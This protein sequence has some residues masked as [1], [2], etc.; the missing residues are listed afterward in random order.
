M[1]EKKLTKAELDKVGLV[2]IEID[3]Q[4][5]QKLTA[6]FHY[7]ATQK[8]PLPASGVNDRGDL[9]PNLCLLARL[10]KVVQGKQVFKTAYGRVALEQALKKCGIEDV[11]TQDQSNETAVVREKMQD[12][13]DAVARNASTTDTKL[14]AALAKVAALTQENGELRNSV[15]ELEQVLNVTQVKLGVAQTRVLAVSAHERI[16]LKRTC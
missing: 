1:A 8:E 2:C 11:K 4:N 6:L 9:T 14:Q 13:I 16:T 3:W 12:T 10:G 5:K 7:F 15:R